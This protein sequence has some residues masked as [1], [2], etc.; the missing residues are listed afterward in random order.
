MHMYLTMQRLEPRA[1]S[2][3]IRSAVAKTGLPAARQG[4]GSSALA[5]KQ[6]VAVQV[7]TLG[8]VLHAV[9]S[10][11]RTTPE[12][13]KSPKL[14]V[15]QRWRVSMDHGMQALNMCLYYGRDNML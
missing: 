13:C 12:I 7:W 3:A 6:Q 14:T 2:A 4:N 1:P 8:L 15:S 9:R 11:F 10:A 5:G